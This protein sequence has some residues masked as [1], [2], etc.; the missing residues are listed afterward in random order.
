MKEKF[1]NNAFSDCKVESFDRIGKI[2]N[3]GYLITVIENPSL[4]FNYSYLLFIPANPNYDSTI[5]VEG[6]NT[7]GSKQIFDIDDSK[8]FIEDA[9]EDVKKCFVENGNPIEIIN[10]QTTNYPLLYPLFPRLYY[11]G[12]T[13]YNHMLST[14][15]MFSSKDLEDLK[16]LGLYRTD[17][18]L[19]EMIKN[20]RKR[21][22][23][24]GLNV[25]EKV[26]ITGFSASSKFANRFTI[27]HPEIVK[28]TIGGG[29]GGTITLPIREINGEKLLWPIGIGN[30][31]EI[32]DEKLEIYKR[33]PQFYYQGIK[34]NNDS[35]QPN[36]FGTCKHPGIL[37][38]DEA[39]QFYKYLGK[40]MNENRW[41]KT[42]EIIS[43]LD[44]D[45]RLESIDGGH[46]P[47]I[48]NNFVREI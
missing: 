41:N 17:L 13:F 5:I 30:V 33:V 8:E 19:I 4:G 37:E 23:E 29:V 45:I 2:V 24:Y 40:E 9:I 25:E 36:E 15:S 7:Y 31:E 10:E 27:L 28:Y 3:G 14:N 42:K 46:D 11:R 21:L 12:R 16:K 34:D 32:T 48:A 39:R 20:A 26:I 47:N 38:D 44:C 18:Q 6:A 22:I 43:S 1:N 35:Y